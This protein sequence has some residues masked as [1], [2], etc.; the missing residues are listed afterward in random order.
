LSIADRQ[1]EGSFFDE[2]LDDYFAES[3]EHLTALRRGLLA[4]E[5]FIGEPQIDRL[6]LDE[7]FRSFHSL[8]GISGMVGVREAEH[9]AHELE[10]YL[11]ALRQDNVLLSE[12]GLETLI[13]GAKMLEQVVAARR[14]MVA[15]PDIAPIIARIQALPLQAMPL[16]ESSASA[17]SATG[18][19]STAALVFSIEQQ[20]ADGDDPVIEPGETEAR[21]WLFEFAPTPE[22]AERGISV[23]TVRARLQEIGDLKSSSPRALPGGG[24]VFDFIVSS[25][26]NESSFAALAQEGLIYRQQQE[27]LPAPAEQTSLNSAPANAETSAP[28]IAPSNIVRVNL[29]RL[30]ELMRMVGEL[31][32]SRARLEGNLKE[33]EPEMPAPRWRPLQETNLMIERQLRDLREAVMRVR[34][35]PVG[36]IFERMRFVVRDL[37][38]E[39]QKKVRLD[40]SGQETE[41]DKLLIER[42]MD[43]LM[44]LVRNAISHGLEPLSERRA[45]GKPDEGLIR[46]RAFTEAETVVI[47]VEDDG[48]GVDRERVRERAMQMGLI[49]SDAPMDDQQLLDLICSPGFST[50]EE[51]DRASGRGVGM[52]VV[53][54]TILGLG[55]EFRLSSEPGRGAR[56]T[57]QLPV[58]LA[59]ADALIVVA[60]GQKFAVP[61]SA[62]R[63][64]I[65]V[66]AASVKSFENNE[67]IHYR[68]GVLPI[69]RLSQLFRTG[70]KYERAFH[71]FVVGQGLNAAGIAVDRILGQREIVVR[72]INDPLIQVA[73][74][75]GATEL[76]DGRVV[77]ILDAAAIVKQRAA[78]RRIN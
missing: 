40:L 24:V 41:I 55:G 22:L 27:S 45:L 38:R 20:S 15:P 13:Q 65:E 14:E 42:M 64:V 6:L 33:A 25:H 30:D 53:Q 21:L 2:F 57:I 36:E 4:L 54:N 39:Y 1:P 61:Q 32:I 34:M 67:I 48:R 56:F 23:T 58:T 66:E 46:L 49:A 18:A 26:R 72:A 35:A 76:G 62:V 69:V 37:A 77:L 59:I 71:A 29:S 60:G 10:S 11:R 68:G 47:E 75:A 52:A 17:K 7:L 8:K 43:P 70:E 78:G 28:A 44:H 31:V 51:A 12:E 16:N 9:L 19:G 74:I 5:S 50:R 3:E 73:G 63:E